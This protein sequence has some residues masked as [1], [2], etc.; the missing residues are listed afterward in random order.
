MSRIGTSA[1]ADEPRRSEG[2]LTSPS[3]PRRLAGI[4]LLMTVVVWLY[5]FWLA[6]GR[7]WN[8]DAKDK[9]GLNGEFFYWSQAKSL[10]HGQVYAVTPRAWWIECFTIHSKCYGYFGITPSIVRIPAVLLFPN[11]FVGLVPLFVALAIALAFWAAM[12]LVR[13]VLNQYLERN[14]GVSLSTGVRWLIVTGALLGPG[15]VLVL[16]SRGR[17]YEE[18]GAWC[19]AFLALTMN[20]VYRW[21]KNRSN[22]C[23]AGVI[24]AGSLATLARPSAIP[25]VIVL[26]IAVIVIAW[27]GGST[28][29]RLLGVGLAIV[30]AALFVAVFLRKFHSLGFPWQDYSPYIRL[31]S[32]RAVI[33]ANH[34]STVGLRFVLTTLANYFRPDSLHFQLSPPW[35][36]LRS[37][38]PSDL[39]VLPPATRQQIYGNRVPSLTDVMPVPIVFTGIALV[40]QAKLVLKRKLS[41]VSLMPAFM[42]VAGLAA[43][44]PLLMYYA[45]EGRYLGDLYPLMAV[46]TAFSLPIIFDYVRRSQRFSRAI[47]PLVVVFAAASCVILYQIRNSVF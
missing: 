39:I 45:V 34:D 18:A 20:L 14:P 16:L 9:L 17:V 36:T 37:I 44:I 40:S 32:F 15:S 41:G 27:R 21:S 46:G 29:V 4:N 25:A 2:D 1:V 24:V 43:G 10:I 5:A 26:G 22:L 11:T 3:K 33:L 31:A 30:P 13:L 6:S 42:L 7:T 35:V 38:Q 28:R 12:D 47:L 8:P 19:A 23:L